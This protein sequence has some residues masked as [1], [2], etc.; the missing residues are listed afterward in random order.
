M[1]NT[2]IVGFIH[3]DDHKL[4]VYSSL[5]EPIFKASDVANLVDYSNNT[6]KLLELCEADEKLNLPMVV[7]GQVRKVS[8]VTEQ[9]LYN[10][11]S[12][13]RK[14]IARKWRKIIGQE[15]INLRKCC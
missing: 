6:W 7:A 15:L 2:T 13:S 11:L 5:D 14:P 1:N 10:I 3:F 9:G 8:F 4:D 12:Q